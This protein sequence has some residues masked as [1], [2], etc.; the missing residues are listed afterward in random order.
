M[1]CPPQHLN[2]YSKQFLDSYLSDNGF[3]FNKRFYTSGGMFNPFSWQ[4]Q[5]NRVF[6]RLMHEYDKRFLNKIAIFDHMYNY[7]KKIN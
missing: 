4:K 6:S 7:Y 5:L 2:F 1:Y 3:K